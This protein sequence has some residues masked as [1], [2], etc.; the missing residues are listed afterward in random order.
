MGTCTHINKVGFGL[1]SLHTCI[2]GKSIPQWCHLVSK[3]LIQIDN[4]SNLIVLDHKHC[5]RNTLYPWSVGCSDG[6]WH[7]RWQGL[8]VCRSRPLVVCRSRPLVVC[9]ARPLVF[10]GRGLWWFVGRASGGLSGPASGGL[11]GPASG[12]CWTRPLVVCRARPLVVCRAPARQTTRGRARQTTRGRARQ[13]TRGRERQTTRGRERQT[14]RP[15]QRWCQTPSEHPTD[16]GYSVFWDSVYDLKLLNY[17]YCQFV[18]MFCSLDGTTVE[19]ISHWYMYVVII[20]QNP[21]CW[22]VCTC[23]CE[24]MCTCKLWFGQN[25]P[26]LLPFFTSLQK[27]TLDN[28]QWSITL[29]Y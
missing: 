16:H 11:S 21:P 22:C 23:P 9:R 18:L 24:C 17:C 26:K 8:A 20:D 27:T 28:Q 13:T 25:K 6:V 10:V 3:T 5:L 1:W 4:N 29:L 12:C 14:A 19:L 7:Q 15:C 2:S